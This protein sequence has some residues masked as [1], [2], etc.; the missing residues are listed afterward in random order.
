VVEGCEKTAGQ[1]D[2]DQDWSLTELTTLDF[3]E[4]RCTQHHAMKTV[5]GWTTPP[6]AGAADPEQRPLIP[7]AP[8][9]PPPA[10][11]RGRT[12]I[13]PT[14]VQKIKDH[15]A[16]IEEQRRRQPKPA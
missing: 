9:D 3:L 11:K 7:P 15:L 4:H 8:G 16:G 6:R 13:D 5:D 14:L 2:H 1:A 12:G 10:V